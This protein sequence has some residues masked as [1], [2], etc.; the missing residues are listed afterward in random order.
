[1]VRPVRHLVLDKI[2]WISPFEQV[3]FLSW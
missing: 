3:N 2:E 1:M